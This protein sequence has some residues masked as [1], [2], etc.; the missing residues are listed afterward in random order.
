MSQDTGEVEA[1]REKSSIQSILHRCPKSKDRMLGC[2]LCSWHQPRRDE[3]TMTESDIGE[4]LGTAPK[5]VQGLDIVEP[6][7]GC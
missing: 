1:K 5:G 7:C 3:S 2:L 6:T 4:G